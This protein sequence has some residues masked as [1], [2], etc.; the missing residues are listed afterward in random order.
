SEELRKREHKI[1]RGRADWELA[2]EPDADD[3]RPRKVRR[4]AEHRGFG[5]D[6]ADAPAEHAQAVDHRGV[7]VGAEERVR[8]RD[9]VAHDHD[10]REPLEIN[11]MADPRARRDD[12]ERLEGLGRPAEDRVALAV[13]FV[14]ALEVALVHVARAEEVVLYRVVDV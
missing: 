14:L 4:L 12:A 9:A 1:G 11:L 10:L 2:L 3:D 5:L 8:H 7:R 6:A 13:T